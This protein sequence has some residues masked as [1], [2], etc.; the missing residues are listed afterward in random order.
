MAE[1]GLTAQRPEAA[2]SAG[3]TSA[4]ELTGSRSRSKKDKFGPTRAWWFQAREGGRIALIQRRSQDNWR[5]IPVD[6]YTGGFRNIDYLGNHAIRFSRFYQ[7]FYRLWRQ[8][9]LAWHEGSVPGM[10]AAGIDIVSAQAVARPLRHR[11]SGFRREGFSAQIPGK[12]GS[13]QAGLKPRRAGNTSD[14]RKEMIP[15]QL[16]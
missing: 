1:L 3:P 16:C 12:M 5:A 6:S 8:R 11:R 2:E 15:P 7:T 13:R 10:I 9:D 14:S 4:F